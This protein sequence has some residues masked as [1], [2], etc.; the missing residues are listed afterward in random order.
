MR[1]VDAAGL[2]RGERG[3]TTHYQVT[4]GP[5]RGKTD[6]TD[7]GRGFPMST[8]IEMIKEAMA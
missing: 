8:Y 3:I 6:H 5:G 4:L 2:L 1:Y 7:P